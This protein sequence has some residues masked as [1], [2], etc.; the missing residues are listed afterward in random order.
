MLRAVA[1]ITGEA[2]DRRTVRA[3]YEAGVPFGR[4]VPGYRQE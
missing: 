3:Q 2:V 1:L 4:P